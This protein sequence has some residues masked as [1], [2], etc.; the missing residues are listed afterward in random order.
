MKFKGTIIITD[1]CYVLKRGDDIDLIT[2]YIPN[3]ISESTIYG[4]WSC[5]TFEL[6][7]PLGERE[8]NDITDSDVKPEI[9]GKFCADGGLVGVFLLEEVLKYN[10]D[11][12]YHITKPWTTTLIEDFDG[13]VVYNLS[14]YESDDED[15]IFDESAHIVGTGNVNFVTIQTGL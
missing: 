2:S 10:P 8:I 11:F 12:D 7:E 15:D 1:P 14:M 13:N 5:I 9:L 3:C 4:D 6:K